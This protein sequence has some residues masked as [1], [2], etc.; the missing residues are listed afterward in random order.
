MKKISARE[1][2][3]QCATCRRHL[4]WGAATRPR[5]RSGAAARERTE[6]MLAMRERDV[7]AIRCLWCRVV[8]CPKC[9]ERHFA[10]T[11][12]TMAALD[13]RLRTVALRMLKGIE[14]HLR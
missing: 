8:L 1:R 13:K 11:E 10:T 5:Y 2:R 4:V 14:D 9:A 12:K 6:F 3:P 7:T